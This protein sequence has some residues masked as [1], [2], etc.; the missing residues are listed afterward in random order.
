MGALLRVKVPPQADHS[1]RS[2]RPL[3]FAS[4]LWQDKSDGSWPRCCLHVRRLRCEFA[5]A[6]SRT[7]SVFKLKFQSIVVGRG[8]KRAIIAI[9]HEILRTI[10][11]VLKRRE[12]Y[13]DSATPAMKPGPFNAMPA[14]DQNP[15]QV[16]ASSPPPDS[17]HGSLNHDLHRSGWCSPRPRALSRSC[18]DFL[19]AGKQRDPIPQVLPFSFFPG[20]PLRSL[21]TCQRGTAAWRCMP[22]P[23][24]PAEG[25]AIG[26]CCRK[27]LHWPGQCRIQWLVLAFSRANRSFSA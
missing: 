21:S 12:H 11:F 25:N 2:D 19:T 10:F 7:T 20:A 4:L 9:G 17:S 14:L 22:A 24:T 8:Y 13:R 26:D 1:E 15:D 5:H 3:I 16:Q 6:A 27:H 18:A 23:E